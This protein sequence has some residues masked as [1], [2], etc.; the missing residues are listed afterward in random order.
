ML[1]CKTI[2]SEKLSGSLEKSLKEPRLHLVS[3]HRNHSEEYNAAN[4]TSILSRKS[5]RFTVHF[6]LPPFGLV[7]PTSRSVLTYS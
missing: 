4:Q 3:N 1:S 5:Q 2:Y 6:K 7:E